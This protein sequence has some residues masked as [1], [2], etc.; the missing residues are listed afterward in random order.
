[1][2][3]HKLAMSRGEKDASR[4]GHISTY[5][6]RKT[7]IGCGK[8]RWLKYASV[9]FCVYYDYI[10]ISVYLFTFYCCNIGMYVC[11][12]TYINEVHGVVYPA[13]ETPS[14]PSVS[15]GP[16]HRNTAARVPPTR[17]VHQT[18]CQIAKTPQCGIGPA[19]PSLLQKACM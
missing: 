18:G 6:W 3:C 17:T 13:L 2:G 14:P 8:R 9:L 16:G 19:L 7:L 5:Y 10:Y 1:M 12:H 11:M 4:G 15:R